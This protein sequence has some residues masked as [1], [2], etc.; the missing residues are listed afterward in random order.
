MCKKPTISTT[1]SYNSPE[2][3]QLFLFKMLSVVLHIEYTLFRD[4]V[5]SKPNLCKPYNQI[6][7]QTFCKK[8]S[9]N[10]RIGLRLQSSITK[11]KWINSIK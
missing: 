10:C 6:R 11:M 1:I 9:T 7:L 2:P 3:G 8:K 4:G 5:F